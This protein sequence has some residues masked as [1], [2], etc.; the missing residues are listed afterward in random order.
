M[1]GGAGLRHGDHLTLS[2]GWFRGQGAPG[3]TELLTARS[4]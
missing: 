2:A 4:G 1:L 3:R